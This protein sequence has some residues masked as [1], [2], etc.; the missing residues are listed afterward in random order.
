MRRLVW[1]SLITL[2]AFAL[3]VHLLGNQELRGDEGFTWNYIQQPPAEIL[4]TIIREGD[5]QPPLHYWLQWTW[6]QLTGY[7]EF[8]MRSGSAFLSLL[9][10]PLMYQVGRK[11]WRAEIGLLAA[12]LTA[13]HPQ[14]IWLAQD[15]RN[16]YQLALIFLLAATLV[17]PGYKGADARPAP[18]FRVWKHW[19][20]YVICG[21]LAMYSHYYA[22]FFLVAHG[23]YIAGLTQ[24]TQKVEA[25]GKFRAHGALRAPC[26]LNLPYFLARGS[27]GKAW[28]AAGLAIAALV[29]PW[30]FT[31]LPVYS[32]GQLADPGSLPFSQYTFAAFGDLL[33]GSAFPDSVK[34]TFILASLLICSVYF[35]IRPAIQS[36]LT[37]SRNK[38]GKFRVGRALRT[39]PTLNLPVFSSHWRKSSELP[40]RLYLIA[41]ILIPFFGVY[42]ITFTRA[43]FNSFYFVFAFPAVYLLTAGAVFTLYQKFRPLGISVVLLGL[44]AY[45]VGL[46][47]HYNV[48]Q[49]SKTRGMREVVN[50]L[51]T[52]AEPGDIYLANFPDPA[53]VYY[54][55][56]LNLNYRMQPGQIGFESALVDAELD[57]LLANRVWFVPVQSILD[58]D[59][60]VLSQLSRTGI[61]AEDNRFYKMQLLLFLPPAAAHP[62]AA[63]FADGI[64]LTGYY[65]TP[66]RLT[67]L[68]AADSQPAADYT[69]FVHALAAD[70]FNLAGHDAPPHRPTSQW[71]PGQLIIDV[72]EFDLSTN[73]PVTLVAGMY[74]PETGERLALKT[75]SFGEPNAARITELDLRTGKKGEANLGGAGR[76]APRTP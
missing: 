25:I 46:N 64:R 65:L 14:Q 43:T 72:H 75:E 35:F 31:I 19:L 7:T 76:S 70:T 38:E 61:L 11:L 20:I 39:L 67:L 13:I 12:A 21:A 73:Q 50:H 68:W 74:L 26:A 45:S 1:L 33:A 34:L 17:L 58:P 48:A 9:L 3:R 8:A 37:Q 54:V 52:A 23:V 41:A 59:Q 10:A 29:A 71:Q 18:T 15:V 53:Q 60:Y 47:N 27:G 42:A 30:A 22:L 5:P 6:A 63:R 69:V 28:L 32:S 16:M 49:Y 51:T 55:Y 4:A 2:I 24:L 66:N 57:R 36:G 44:I 40:L 62:L 56:D